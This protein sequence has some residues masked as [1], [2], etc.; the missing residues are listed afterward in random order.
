MKHILTIFATLL[1]TINVVAQN[2]EPTAEAAPAKKE[3]IK[4]IV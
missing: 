1:A 3:I 2:A 4:T